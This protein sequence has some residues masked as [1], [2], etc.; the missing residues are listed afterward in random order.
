MRRFALAAAAV[1]LALA[2]ALALD[3]EPAEEKIVSTAVA[4]RVS[5]EVTHLRGHRHRP[6]PGRLST[7]SLAISSQDYIR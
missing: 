4:E 1:L 3:G 5:D 2:P 6:G 7:A